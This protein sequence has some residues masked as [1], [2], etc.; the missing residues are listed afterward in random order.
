[1]SATT[2]PPSVLQW[3]ICLRTLASQMLHGQ[4]RSNPNLFLEM[5]TSIHRPHG[6]SQT[7]YYRE[8]AAALGAW[9]KWSAPITAGEF[10]SSTLKSPNSLRAAAWRSG[11]PLG[12]MFHTEAER[13]SSIKNKMAP[14]LCFG[15]NAQMCIQLVAGDQF[16]WFV[17]RVHTCSGNWRWCNL[18]GW[19]ERERVRGM[20]WHR[21][22]QSNQWDSDM[23][24]WVTCTQRTCKWE[25]SKE[26]TKKAFLF[27]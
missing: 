21:A 7:C 20:R 10:L 11:L 14:N 4:T 22:R 19:P 18:I 27:F 8:P 2:A 6:L 5:I 3:V 26:K 16:S 23:W 9:G 1:M 17:S 15:R 13:V 25:C 24:A 12:L